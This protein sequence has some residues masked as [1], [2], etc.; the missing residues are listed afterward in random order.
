MKKGIFPVVTILSALLWFPSCQSPDKNS[1]PADS[2]SIATGKTVFMRNCASCHN[3]RT[4]GIAP[5]LGDVF[6]ALAPGWVK[7]FIRDPKSMI[8]SGDTLAK[9]LFD[10][11]HVMMPSFALSDADMEGL[12]AYIHSR[13]VD[14]GTRPKA[15]PNFI[16]DPIPEKIPMS[17]LLVELQPV[18]QLPHVSDKLPYT[19]GAKLDYQ[20]HTD[21]I[22]ILDHTGKLYK[23]ADNKTP[24]VYLDMAAMRPAFINRPG[25]A[26]GFGS[27]AFHP[28]FAKN[29]LLYTTHTEAARTK[30]A[31]F[32]YDDSIQVQMQWVLTEWKTDRP[33]TV[34][35]SGSSRELLRVNMVSGIHGVQEII[36]DPLAK[37][38]SADY[39]LLY[40]GVGDGGS[41]ENG[42]PFLAHHLNRVWGSILRIDPM[43][44]NS[45]NGQYGIP[46]GNPFYK[47]STSGTLR[48]IFAY[49]FRNPHKIT[50]THNGLMLASNVGQTN[51]ESLYIILPGHD[52]GWPIREGNFL[53]NPVGDIS[54]VYALP[55][56]DT[57]YHISYPA[58][59]Y[60]HDEGNAISGGYEYEGS[61]IP[62][63]KGKYLFGDIANGRLFYVNIA[64]L[65]PGK[66]AMIKEW[67]ISLG[68]RPTTMRDLCGSNR[69]E[70]R[71]G[72]DHKGEMYVF[73]KAD[74][75]VY[76]LV[77]AVH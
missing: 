47:D 52:Y 32:A 16:T 23:L 31:D 62:E 48:E 77:K 72:R 58:A 71:F 51:I 8:E 28:D 18:I 29:G 41:V 34:P 68:G 19:R 14:A 76:R 63:L 27:F 5:A 70:L 9:K 22:F 60:D 26:T 35:F 15:D 42:Y 54:K 40:I 37:P 73:A 57:A 38:G 6:P 50:W 7:N 74:G 33:G 46:A 43:G 4:D 2:L 21:S 25:L 39:G 1:I 11:Y 64:D 36:F 65:K 3:F 61:A 66:Q 45:K 75:K 55:P 17:D 12:L 49:G 59:E 13:R 30:P 56:N 67:R 10:Q 24:V 53:L 44:R 20:P 69:V